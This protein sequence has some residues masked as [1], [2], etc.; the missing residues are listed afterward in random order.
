MHAR[1]HTLKNKVN[2][3]KMHLFIGLYIE[4][5]HVRDPDMMKAHLSNKSDSQESDSSCDLRPQCLLYGTKHNC[6]PL[7]AISFMGFCLSGHTKRGEPGGQFR[8]CSRTKMKA[9]D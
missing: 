2:I 7:N 4:S 5:V 6:I 8:F 9:V 1:A 3:F